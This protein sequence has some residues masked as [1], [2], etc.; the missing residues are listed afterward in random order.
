[1]WHV[2]YIFFLRTLHVQY[3]VLNI[4]VWDICAYMWFMWKNDFSTQMIRTILYKKA[5]AGEPPAT[6][7]TRS[8]DNNHR[9]FTFHGLN[10]GLK[11]QPYRGLSWC[12]QI[13]WTCVLGRFTCL[14]QPKGW[15]LDLIC[16]EL[17]ISPLHSPSLIKS[18]SPHSVIF[19]TIVAITWVLCFFKT[20]WM[21][22][23]TGVWSRVIKDY[24]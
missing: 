19:A 21:L 3:V 1:M 10:S 9:A 15:Y 2:P 16:A 24:H 7:R 14:V 11:L 6:R 17:R 13:S 4:L 5:A 18:D 8:S 22:K 20:H 12:L 23:K